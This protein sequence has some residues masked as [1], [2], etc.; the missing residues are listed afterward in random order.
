[1]VLHPILPCK[2]VAPSLEFNFVLKKLTLSP[3]EPSHQAD[4]RFITWKTVLLI[5]LTSA[6]RVCDLQELIMGETYKFFH[7]DR[8]HIKNK[9]FIHA[10]SG[11]T[12]YLNLAMN[13]PLF[14]TDLQNQVERTLHTV[15]HMQLRYRLD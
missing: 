15:M 3:D 8:G 1:M 12:V 4:L 7:R 6:R 5:A 13:L 11:V 14:C 2:P 9:S 10:Q